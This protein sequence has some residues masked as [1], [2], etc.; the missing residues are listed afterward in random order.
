[1]E[2]LQGLQGA[3]CRVKRECRA[4]CGG[5]SELFVERC[6]AV[7]GE[8]AGPL[9]EWCAHRMQGPSIFLVEC[10]A[11]FIDYSAVWRD[12]CVERLLCGENAGL[13]RENSGLF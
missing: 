10:R 13:C 5:I 12:C 9:R 3:C 4:L 2:R 1:M 7:C 11:L 6:W 8:N